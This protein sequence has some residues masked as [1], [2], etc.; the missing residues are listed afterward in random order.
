VVICVGHDLPDGDGLGRKA[1]VRECDDERPARLQDPGDIRQ[2]ASW[3]GFTA[4]LAA[5]LLDK[6]FDVKIASSGA[7]APPSSLPSSTARRA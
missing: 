4:K 5:P 1:A 7:G 3:E 6:V 2:H